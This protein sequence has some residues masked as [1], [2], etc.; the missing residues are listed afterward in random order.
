MI[1]SVAVRPDIDRTYH[2]CG[3]VCMDKWRDAAR[4]KAEKQRR[5]R[6]E[7]RRQVGPGMFTVPNLPDELK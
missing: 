4:E 6:E 1:Y 7:N 2:F 5:W 3:L